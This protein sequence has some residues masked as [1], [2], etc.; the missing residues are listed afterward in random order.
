MPAHAHFA[1]RCAK[2]AGDEALYICISGAISGTYQT[3]CATREL[4]ESDDCYV[5][6]SR[7]ATGGLRVIL[8]YAAKLRDEG[9]SAKEIMAALEDVQNRIVLYACMDRRLR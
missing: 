1:R 6:D 9:K 8:E 7:N 2:A 4:A 3:A 5:L